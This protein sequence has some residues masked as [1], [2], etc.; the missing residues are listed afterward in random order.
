VLGVGCTRHGVEAVLVGRVQNVSV[1]GE[2]VVASDVHVS[3]K[4]LE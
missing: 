1:K 4:Y 2:V 3:P